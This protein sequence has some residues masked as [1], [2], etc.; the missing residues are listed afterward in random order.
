MKQ[1]RHRRSGSRLFAFRI[2]I[3]AGYAGICQ[4]ERAVLT[5]RSTNLRAKLC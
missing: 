5:E 2:G 1:A 4:S 3:T